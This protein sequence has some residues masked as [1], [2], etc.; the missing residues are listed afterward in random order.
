MVGVEELQLVH[1]G[2]DDVPFRPRSV[3][4]LTEAVEID[5]AR[6]SDR[7]AAGS[8]VGS[9]FGSRSASGSANR[10]QQSLFAFFL[11]A[12]SETP[13]SRPKALKDKPSFS[14]PSLALSQSGEFPSKV[15]TGLH[16]I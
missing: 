15:R 8:R 2:E 5:F 9:L 10:C 12:V 11:T 1:Q 16:L 4:S 7:V 13:I 6:A 3:R 14:N